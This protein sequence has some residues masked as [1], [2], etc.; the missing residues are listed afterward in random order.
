MHLVDTRT[1][2]GRLQ[3][4]QG[5][6]PGLEYFVEHFGGMLI[7]LSNADGAV[8]N[9]LAAAPAHSPQKR[10]KAVTSYSWSDLV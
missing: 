6:Q 1:G 7:I 4:V 9:C 5:R 3:L 2:D 10:C 8:D